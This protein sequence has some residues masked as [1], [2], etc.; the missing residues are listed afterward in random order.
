MPSRTTHDADPAR[1]AAENELRAK[2]ELGWKQS[3]AGEGRDG[4]IVFSEMRE[5]LQAKL[6]TKDEL[7]VALPPLRD[8]SGTA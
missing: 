3:E 6:V 8:N 1:Q 2:I 7:K 5:R 4:E